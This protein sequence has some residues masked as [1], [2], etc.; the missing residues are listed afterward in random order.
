MSGDPS[1]TS[2]EARLLR[3]PAPPI[4]EDAHERTRRLVRD[5]LLRCDRADRPA[6]RR[7]A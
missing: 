3:Q 4:R 5:S 6:H 7:W 2:P 1:P